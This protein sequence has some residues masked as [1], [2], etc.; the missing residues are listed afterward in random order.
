M[1]C[2]PET[3]HG[4]HVKRDSGMSQGWEAQSPNPAPLGGSPWS[5]LLEQSSQ[6][7]LTCCMKACTWLLQLA[8]MCCMP[9]SDPLQ[10]FI[11]ASL[12]WYIWLKATSLYPRG[13][14]SPSNNRPDHKKSDFSSRSGIGFPKTTKWSSWCDEPFKWF[15]FLA[16]NV[17]KTV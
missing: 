16:Q 1:F 12:V 5:L 14:H 6:S 3:T 2:E 17:S 7:M 15:T 9:S 8:G 13:S 4:V 11:P 10:L